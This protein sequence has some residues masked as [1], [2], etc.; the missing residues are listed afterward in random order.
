MSEC[1]GTVS[2][3]TKVDEEMRDFLDDEA[4]RLGVTNA[5]LHRL[6]LDFYRESRENDPN[7]PHCGEP[8]TIELIP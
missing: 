3:G 2:A 8:T 5:E 4:D 6:L 1:M 7:C